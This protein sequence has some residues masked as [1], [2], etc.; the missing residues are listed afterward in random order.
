MQNDSRVKIVLLFPTLFLDKL[1]IDWG[2][3]I[4]LQSQLDYMACCLQATL[5]LFTNWQENGDNENW[6]LEGFQYEIVCHRNCASVKYQLI[7]ESGQTAALSLAGNA[8]TSNIYLDIHPLI[9][10]IQS[11][12]LN[13]EAGAPQVT[14]STE[15]LEMLQEHRPNPKDPSSI[16]MEYIQA[17]CTEAADWEKHTH[18]LCNIDIAF[19]FH[20]DK[21]SFWF[22]HLQ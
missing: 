8:L 17:W 21:V 12:F 13:A 16:V 19:G 1:D 3:Y 4:Y 10:G 18:W 14:L 20:I 15:M 22:L 5:N 9:C 2:C 6:W 7:R 11:C